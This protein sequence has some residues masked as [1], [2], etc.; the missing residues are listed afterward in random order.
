MQN[1]LLR[2]RGGWGMLMMLRFGGPGS[3]GHQPEQTTSGGAEWGY[4]IPGVYFHRIERF[5]KRGLTRL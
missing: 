2:A 5:H 3:H 1:I 4:F